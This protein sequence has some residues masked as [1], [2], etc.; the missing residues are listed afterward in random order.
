MS[1]LKFTVLLLKISSSFSTSARL[2]VFSL[3]LASSGLAVPL[4][5][6]VDSPLRS[7]IVTVL[8]L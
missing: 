2:E 5:G 7:L 1:M 3:D 6:T 4:A 8:C